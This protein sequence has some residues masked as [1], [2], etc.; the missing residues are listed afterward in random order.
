MPVPAILQLLRAETR[1]YHDAVEQN[2][3]NR[4]LAAGTVTA[5]HTATFL[6]KMYGV[7]APYENC[8]RAHAAEFGSAWQLERRYRAHLILQDLPQLGYVGVPPHCPVLPPLHTKPALLGA[9]YVLEG[10]TLGGQVLARQLAQAGISATTYFRG[11]G[12]QTGPLWKE[13]C[14]QLDQEVTSD[15]RIETLHSAKLLFKCL[16]AWL[17]QPE[18]TPL[19]D[20]KTPLLH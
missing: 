16:S 6:A 8:L 18:P 1:P 2:L 13:F 14:Q 11:H 9:L 7:L 10:S 12:E 3:F 4:A 5:E 17:T 20:L 19:P 15:N